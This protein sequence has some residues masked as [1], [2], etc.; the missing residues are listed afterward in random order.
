M[1]YPNGSI[2]GLCAAAS[3][4]FAL[5]IAFLAAWGFQGQ[6]HWR[7]TDLFVVIP[8]FLASCGFGLTPWVATRPIQP[9]ECAARRCYFAS[10]I[11]VMLAVFA[12]LIV[13]YSRNSQ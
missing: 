3:T 8:L 11:F 13:E 9:P 6:G 1:E 2:E 7:A 10:V 4:G 5:C 12:A